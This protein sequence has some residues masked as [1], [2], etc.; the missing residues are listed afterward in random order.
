VFRPVSLFLGLRYTRAKKR[1]HFISFIS[2]TSMLGIAIGVAVLITVLAVMNGFDDQIKNRIFELAPQ[3]VVR[4]FNGTIEDWQ[5]LENRVDKIP[6]VLAAAPFVS[7][8]GMLTYRGTVYPAVIN[9]IIPQQE[10]TVS[11]INLKMTSGSLTNLQPGEFGIVLGK[12]L[13]Q[14]L[15]AKLGDKITL[16]TPEATLS[17][18]GVLPNFKRFKVVGIFHAGNGFGFDNG[19]AYINMAD[20]QA[21]LQLDQGVSGIRLKISDLYAAPKISQQ[22]ANMISNDYYVTNWTNDYG[23]LFDAIRLEK[24]MMFIILLLIVAVAAFNLVSSLVMVVNDKRAEIAI[25]R[26]LGATPKMIMNSFMIQGIIVG[27]IGTL[28][29]LIGGVLLALNVTH[30]VAWL[31][32]TFHVTLFSSNVYYVNYL[33]SKLALSDVVKICMAAFGLCLIATIYPALRAAAT[34]PAE[35]LRYE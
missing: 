27:C 21:L 22:I 11:K 30:I 17:A 31:E 12:E 20:A 5:S 25:L 14:N 6:G 13:A 19:L 9:G 34:E 33:P 4:S 10:A 24:T 29:G 16:V 8:Q 26:T 28:L 7:G 18:V 2:L 23:S 3:V 1:N 15:S 35:A 32:H